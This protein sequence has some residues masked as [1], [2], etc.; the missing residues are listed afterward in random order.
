MIHIDYHC[1]GRAGECQFYEKC[2]DTGMCKHAAIESNETICNCD[3]ARVY[4]LLNELADM[5][6]PLSTAY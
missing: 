5:G 4:A 1:L 3:A 2:E 6:T